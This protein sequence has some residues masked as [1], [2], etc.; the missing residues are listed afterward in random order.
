MATQLKTLTALRVSKLT[1][2]GAYSDGGGLYLI[3]DA[4]GAKRWQFRFRWRGARREM[5]LGSLRSVSLEKARSMAAAHREAVADGRDP[6]A[7]RREIRTVPTFG[8]AAD[9]FI[10]K[11]AQEL[12]SAKHVAQWRMTLTTY[13]A[14]LRDVPVDQV[15]TDMVLRLLKPIWK[16]T[17]ETAHRLRGRIERVLDAAAAMKQRSSDNPARWR[18]HL[19][20]FLPRRHALTRGH[21]TALPYAE[22]PALLERVRAIPALAHRALELTILTAT[23]SKE[24]L[25]AVWSEFDLDERVWTIPAVRMKAGREHRVPLSERALEILRELQPLGLGGH[26]FPSPRG[27]KPL[28]NMAMAMVLRRLGVRVT[29]HGF[30]SSFRDW[31]GEET[32]HPREIAEAALAHVVG[33]KTE[34]AYRRG[35]ALTKRRQLMDSW[36]SFCSGGERDNVVTLRT[37]IGR[38]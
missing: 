35:D 36:A 32:D 3:V 34:R 27:D 26:V 13:A 15:D 4:S 8:E 33:D 6:I 38:G 2:A 11:I 25:D 24:V 14:P 1:E 12:K 9:T 22:V 20:H 16:S 30:R 37:V 5:G 31:T 21:H 7:E 29:V 17:P 19:D 10:A 23:R 18:G 28:S